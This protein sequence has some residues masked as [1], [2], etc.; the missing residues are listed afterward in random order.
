MPDFLSDYFWDEDHNRYYDL[1]RENYTDHSFR[2]NQL[3]LIALPFPIVDM[4]NGSAVLQQI[5]T[6]LLTPYGLR[7]LSCREEGYAGKLDFKITRKNP[8]YYRGAVWPWTVGLYVDAVLRFRGKDG[9]T[10]DRL[11]EYVHKFTELFYKRGVGYISEIC[12]GDEPYRSNGTLAYNLNLIELLR[13]LYTLENVKAK[14][15]IKVK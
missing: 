5:E 3:F 1:I 8:P 12:E 14:R 9:D 13:A 7:S 11:R 6:E 10:V 4:K 2:V 15:T